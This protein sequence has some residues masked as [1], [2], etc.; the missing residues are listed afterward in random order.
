MLLKAFSANLRASICVCT[1]LCGAS[2]QIPTIARSK[3]LQKSANVTTAF[4]R[5][6][7]RHLTENAASNV[8][9][10]GGRGTSARSQT[11]SNESELSQREN[12]L[13]NQDPDNFGTLSSLKH[14]LK[15]NDAVTNPSPSTVVDG[16]SEIRSTQQT[17]AKKQTIQQYEAEMKDLF[18]KGHVL[19]AVEL[20]ETEV[21]QKNRMHAPI[22]I[23]NW[24]IEECIRL[25]EFDKGIDIYDQMVGRNLTI[26][27]DIFEK[28]V[29]SYEQSSLTVGKL[30]NIQKVMAKNHIQINAKMYNAM[31]RI[32][33]R[34]T[35]WRTALTL[36]SEIKAHRM[37]YELDTINALF[38]CFAYD[39][40]N[41][42]FSLLEL[43][44]DMHRHNLMPDVSTYNALL[45]CIKKCE[46]NNVVKLTE[47]C[48]TIRT[49]RSQISNEEFIEDGRPNLLRDPPYIGYLVQLEQV[50]RP[51]QRLLMLGGLSKFLHDFNAYDIRP[52]LE[53]IIGLL[54]VVPNTFV[55]HQ[56]VIGLLKKHLIQPDTRLFNVLLQKNC[57]SQNFRNAMVSSK[58]CQTAIGSN[59]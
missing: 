48:E 16:E 47:L 12:D 56:K 33:A 49:Q 37:P 15:T 39:K 26:G 17:V 10:N 34:S 6:K 31:I 59:E 57:E 21:L 25:H 13:L 27:F 7:S 1:P 46:L 8:S 23:Y 2:T 11:N 38:E 53:T 45:K 3:L 9:K 50:E 20:F 5:Q 41:G 54:E 55:A 19:E 22:R 52:T 32:F 35:Q 28:L 18:G 51:D 29:L 44:H 43:W 24:L 14:P 40:D 30:Y 36:A 58:R 4:Y 42:F